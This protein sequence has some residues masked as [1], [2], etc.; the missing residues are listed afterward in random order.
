MELCQDNPVLAKSFAEN[1]PDKAREIDKGITREL[2]KWED[3]VGPHFSGAK[4]TDRF[5]TRFVK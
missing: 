2:L 3:D 4:S 1:N 5:F